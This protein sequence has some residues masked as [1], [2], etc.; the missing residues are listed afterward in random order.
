MRNT[1]VI[2][3]GEIRELLM[4]WDQ[5]RDRII[6]GRT[7]GVCVA[8]LDELEQETIMLGG[9]FKKDPARVLR[10]ALKARTALR[11]P[12]FKVSRM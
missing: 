2:E 12:E 11:Q 3:F 6:S 1:N 10:S 8:L 7:A 9:V 4:I 5:V